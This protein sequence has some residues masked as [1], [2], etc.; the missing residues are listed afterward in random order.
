[1]PRMPE[2]QNKP[3]PCRPQHS[4]RSMLCPPN[5]Q[6]SEEV[7]FDDASVRFFEETSL[8]ICSME[9]IGVQGRQN[10]IT[11]RCLQANA[12]NALS[13]PETFGEYA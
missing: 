2:T 13:Y 7:N 12:L 6:S 9:S 10:R 4:V 5:G 11:K 1:M 3:S 8:G